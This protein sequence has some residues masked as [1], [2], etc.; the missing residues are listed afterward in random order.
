MRKFRRV[1]STV[2]LTVML[3]GTLPIVPISAATLANPFDQTVIN[4][5]SIVSSA[6]VDLSKS[7]LI[8]T[9]NEIALYSATAT[10]NASRK[11]GASGTQTFNM[12]VAIG[13]KSAGARLFTYSMPAK[14]GF[15]ADYL[16]NIAAKFESTHPDWKV[17]VVTN[18]SFYSRDYNPGETEEPYVEDGKTYKYYFETGKHDNDGVP[19]V[20]RGLIGT[21]ENGDFIYYTFETS[22]TSHYKNKSSKAYAFE[23][24]HTLSVLGP[25]D[26]PI[27]EYDVFQGKSGAGKTL[28]NVTSLDYETKITFVTPEMGK[29]NFYGNYVYDITCTNYKCAKT[30]VNNFALPVTDYGYFFEGKISS[31]KLPTYVEGGTA[32]PAGHVYLSCPVTLGHLQVGAKVRGEKQMTGSWADMSSVFAFKQQILLD[33]EP[34]FYGAS[35]ETFSSTSNGATG[36][37]WDSWSEDIYYATYGTNRTAIGFKADGSPVIITAQRNPTGR[38]PDGS[39]KSDSK[40]SGVTYNEMAWYMKSL[41]CVNA[42]MMDSGGSMGMYSKSTN[43]SAYTVAC[44]EPTI[45]A[46]NRELANVLI[47]AYPS[48]KT[49]ATDTFLDDPALETEYITA[50][51]ANWYSGRVPLRSKTTISAKKDILLKVNETLSHTNFSLTQSDN[52]YTLTPN[53]TKGTDGHSMYAYKKLYDKNGN[54]YKIGSGK[55]YS[56]YFKAKT[57][58]STDYASFLFAELTGNNADEKM[59]NNFAVVGGGLSNCSDLNS[60]TTSGT[61]D[62]RL[63]LGRVQSKFESTEIF[64]YNGNINLWLDSNYSYYRLFING[65]T[66]QLQTKHVQGAWV[67]IKVLNG[68]ATTYTNESFEGAQLVLGLAS[69]FNL[70]SASGR[71]ISVKDVVLIDRTALVNKIN[72][73]NKLKSSESLYTATSWAA[74]EYALDRANYAGNL[75]SQGNVDFAVEL[76]TSAMNNLVKQADYDAAVSNKAEYE[77]LNATAGA[78]SYTTESWNAYTEAYNNLASALTNNNLSGIAA[79]NSAYDE[80]KANLVAASVSLDVAWQAMSFTYETDSA[81]WD[82]ETHTY[83]DEGSGSSS[84]WVAN[85]NSNVIELTNN[86]NIALDVGFN[87][88]RDDSVDGISGISGA[89]YSNDSAVTTVAL[90]KDGAAQSVSFMLE[91]APTASLDNVKCGTVTLT[92]TRRKE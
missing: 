1:I 45:S 34:L 53:T 75:T 15:D 92:V 31:V 84:G 81:R 26:D 58:K 59:L 71:N 29:Y 90:D 23:T 30:G 72:E 62:V 47:L 10:S 11:A 48:G 70:G 3:L 36:N 89:F 13:D 86:S 77:N 39:A 51:A 32:V 4:S 55:H 14:S 24:D 9:K 60:S 42:F 74:F 37:Q 12:K 16:N 69:W 43:S 46:P 54:P 33:G 64:L 28:N 44:C 18:A 80:A 50:S 35:R 76:L 25:N 67:T 41:G 65:T 49:V 2:L 19:N 78:N 56:Y 7:E 83:V 85:D 66:V 73:A 17:A 6:S 63:G 27:Y 87:F 68:S 38:N 91:G 57:T 20:G 61:S 5:T 40:E 22:S 21:N 79:L 82:P 52:T 8:G 88:S